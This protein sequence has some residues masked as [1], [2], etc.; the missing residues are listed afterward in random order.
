MKDAL[1]TTPTEVVAVF[2]NF[3]NSIRSESTKQAYVYLLNKYLSRGK[4]YR[5]MVGSIY[6]SARSS[7]CVKPLKSAVSSS[8]YKAMSN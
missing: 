5:L 1:I 8:P 4:Y 7:V 2:E 6:C 3:L